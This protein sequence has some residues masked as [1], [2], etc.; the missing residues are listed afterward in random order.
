MIRARLASLKSAVSMS[1][2]WAIPPNGR[3]RPTGQAHAAVA[4]DDDLAVKSGAQFSVPIL[5]QADAPAHPGH[6]VLSSPEPGAWRRLPRLP[7]WL[8]ARLAHHGEGIVDR[9]PVRPPE[10]MEAQPEIIQVM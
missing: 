9:R 4:G 2:C 10:V 6:E 1:T 3:D 7:V 5:A 8:D